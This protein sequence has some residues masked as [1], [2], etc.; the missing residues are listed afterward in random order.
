[1]PSR[2]GP[3]TRER[4]GLTSRDQIADARAPRHPA[5]SITYFDRFGLTTERGP[6]DELRFEDGPGAIAEADIGIERPLWFEPAYASISRVAASRTGVR[7]IVSV[8][9]TAHLRS[10]AA[11]R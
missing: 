2:T 10:P 1:M 3:S 8:N 5:R 9:E 6:S 4:T 7:S 11:P